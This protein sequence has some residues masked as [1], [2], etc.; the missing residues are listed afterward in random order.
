MHAEL[1]LQLPASIGDGLVAH[2]Q[3]GGDLALDGVL[4]VF[5]QAGFASGSYQ[6]IN[7]SGFLTNNTLDLDPSFL[8]LYPGSFISTS[9]AGSVD[10]VVVPEPG[11]A[12]L[13]LA[14]VAPLLL[15]RRR[16]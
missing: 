8:A 4:Q 9:T 11:T 2:V 12:S 14:G 13:L 7:Y 10:L 5:P 15:R 1:R 6:L 3:V 16:R